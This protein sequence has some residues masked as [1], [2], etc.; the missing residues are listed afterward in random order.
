M[1]NDRSIRQPLSEAGLHGCL[2]VQSRE[3][4]NEQDVKSLTGFGCVS[5]FQCF[6]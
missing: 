2:Q 3:S 6:D 5:D 1:D 4:T